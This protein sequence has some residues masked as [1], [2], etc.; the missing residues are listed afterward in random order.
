MSSRKVNR[1]AR[2]G[3]RSKWEKKTYEI[4]LGDVVESGMEEGVLGVDASVCECGC[5][6]EEKEREKAGKSNVL[7]PDL[8]P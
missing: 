7:S 4:V 1:V 8:L 5:V 2:W 3:V 6:G